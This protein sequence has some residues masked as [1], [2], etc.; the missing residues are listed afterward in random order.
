MSTPKERVVYFLGAGFSAPLGLPVMADFYNTA[1]DM[2]HA[3]PKRYGYVPDILGAAAAISPVKSYYRSDLLHIEE[4]LTI[5]ETDAWLKQEDLSKTFR[6]LIADVIRFRTPEFSVDKAKID[7]PRWGA[8]AFGHPTSN[9]GMIAAFVANLLHWDL[10][11]KQQ[12]EPKSIQISTNREASAHYDVITVN[13]DRVLEQVVEYALREFTQGGP[14]GRPFDNRPGEG[15]ALLKLHGDV[16]EDIVLPTWKKVL[17]DSARATWRYAQTVLEQATHLRVVGYSLPSSDTFIQYLLKAGATRGS[18]LKRIDV[19]CWDPDGVVKGRFEDLVE[20]P[21]F[22][23]L[24]KKVEEYLARMATMYSTSG[25]YE[26]RRRFDSLEY[27][28]EDFFRQA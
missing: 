2:F 24:S 3:D 25:Q 4:I 6:Q 11:D 21:R 23:F 13:Y 15:A 12:G 27:A 10:I 7:N 9:Y 20:F 19:L 8:Y 14:E 28:H 5:L 18:R 16:E 26:P 1:Q 17:G 22:R